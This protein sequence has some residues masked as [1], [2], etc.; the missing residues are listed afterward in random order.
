M[1]YLPLKIEKLILDI[2]Q[3]HH[4]HQQMRRHRHLQQLRSQQQDRV[5]QQASFLLLLN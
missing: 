5:H 1:Y 3:H 4:R 2:R